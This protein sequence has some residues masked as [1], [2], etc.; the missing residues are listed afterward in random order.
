MGATYQGKSIELLVL[1]TTDEMVCGSGF[2]GG[3]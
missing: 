1:S 3:L 2:V